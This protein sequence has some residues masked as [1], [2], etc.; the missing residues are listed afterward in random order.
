M[1]VT[2]TTDLILTGRAGYVYVSR[3]FIFDFMSY[4]LYLLDGSGMN[5]E[6]WDVNCIKAKI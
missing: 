5:Y 6:F 1:K 3:I 2:I 4:S